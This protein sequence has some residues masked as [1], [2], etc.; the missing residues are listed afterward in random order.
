MRLTRF[1]C[2]I[3]IAGTLVSCGRP[4]TSSNSAAPTS[5][6]TT[7]QVDS[8]REPVDAPTATAEPS[9]VT[10]DE[11]AATPSPNDEETAVAGDRTITLSGPAAGTTISSPVTVK[12]ETNYWPFEA[13]L[14]GQVKDANGNIIG[15]APITVQAPDIGQGGP[16][17]GQITFDGPATE[18]EG[19]IEIFEASAK[20]GSIVAMASVP[21]Q[22]AA[23]EQGGLQID[24]PVDGQDIT[25]PLHIAIRIS[26]PVNQLAVR[27]VYSNGT[28]LE[29]P[30]EVVIGSDGVGYA[31]HNLQW[32]TESP[33][34]P[35]EPGAATL[36]ILDTQ[37]NVLKEVPVNILGD[38]AT[39]SVRVAWSSAGEI[40]EFQQRVP[41]TQAI[42]T[43]ALNEL[44]SGP[45]D[46][47]LAGAETALPTVEE[48]VNFPGR[49]EDWGYRVKL[50]GL[51]IEDGVATANFSKELRA[52]GGGSARVQMIRQQI[53]RTL[54][55]FPT[56]DRVVIQI[57]GQS[58]GVLEP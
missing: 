52:Y 45:P 15:V 49:D 25:L 38:E 3:A 7:V 4:A 22:L 27:L 41:R 47:N 33:P 54:L 5:Q 37:G 24:A 17:E 28:E 12:G 16:F 14:V 55:Q 31:V 50:L 57:E 10:S 53:E 46:G 30:I 2:I 39:Q 11:P 20:D 42:G 56:V 26:P 23:S 36:Q 44:L 35:T 43:A 58:E 18:Q 34:P 21:V 13:N 9:P 19:T 40:I 48:I 6:A 32:N 51:T 1:L 29:S 8:T